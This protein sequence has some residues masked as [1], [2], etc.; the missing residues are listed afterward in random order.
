MDVGSLLLMQCGALAVTIKWLWIP[1]RNA[2][3]GLFAVNSF[4]TH[5]AIGH[6]YGSLIYSS[7]VSEKQKW[8]TFREGIRSVT[9][10]EFTNW[11]VRIPVRVTYGSGMEEIS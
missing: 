7:L 6:Y 9:V 2:G 10:Q 8:N 1:Y 11:A 3:W 5:K 4:G